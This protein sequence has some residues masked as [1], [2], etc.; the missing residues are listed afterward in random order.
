MFES[1]VYIVV[2]F[3][4]TVIGALTGI[5]GGIV[6]KTFANIFSNDDVI[7]VGF[8]TTIIVF[9]MCIVSILKQKSKGFKFDTKV[10]IGMSVGSI[11][12]GYLGDYVLNL[13]VLKF[14]ETYVKFIQSI[15]LLITLAFLIIYT[16]IGP[17]I[18]KVENPSLLATSLLGLFLGSI[19]IFLGIG[20]GPLNVSLMVIIFGY[21]MKEAAIYSLSTV[22]FS[23]ISKIIS[24]LIAGNFEKYNL[25]L[26]PFLI[27]VAII[28][29][30]V[31]TSLN[32]KMS[33]KNIELLYVVLMIGLLL[34]TLTSII[35][36]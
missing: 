7:V 8:Y 5:G 25:K 13:F 32:Q 21:G 22:F 12:G 10:L 29:G 36:F 2:S 27:I 15:I 9:T 14:D 33:T 34:L 30:Y 3:I 31:G 6:L 1:I 23:Q 11:V 18:N 4:A 26:V 24:I 28:G 17:K 16:R 19:S 20:G 35:N